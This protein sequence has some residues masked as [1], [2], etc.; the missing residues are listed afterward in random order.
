M[1]APLRRQVP[2]I[3]I[4]VLI[5]VLLLWQLSSRRGAPAPVEAQ[6][7]TDLRFYPRPVPAKA[8]PEQAALTVKTRRQ[9]PAQPSVMSPPAN[10]VEAAPEAVPAAAS[11]STSSAL[12]IDALKR[13][14]RETVRSTTPVSLDATQLTRDD[15]AAQAIARAA[16]PKCDNDYKPQIG[17][18][19]FEGLAKIPFLVKGAA[20]DSGCK[21]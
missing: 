16:R 14:A 5:H 13:Q 1:T 12:D 4:I 8:Q 10:I 19:R 7:V 17:N 9:R 20:S 3:T 11:T 15:K 6:S 2:A 21:W 18:V